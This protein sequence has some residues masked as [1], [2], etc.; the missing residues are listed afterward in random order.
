M[1]RGGGEEKGDG[2][3]GGEEGAEGEGQHGEE[4]DQRLREDGQE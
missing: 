2:R 3:R 4:E 1:V